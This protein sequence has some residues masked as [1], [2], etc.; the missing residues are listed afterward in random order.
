M[1]ILHTS[2][3]HLG[4][5]LAGASRE[6]DHE[7]FLAWLLRAV[8]ELGVDALVVA[9]DVF[10]QA[11]PT[12]DAQRAY[13]GFLAG[14]RGTGVRSVVIVGGNHDS[15]SR[16]DA[17]RELLRAFDV[18]VVGGM[19]IDEDARER[20]VVP[21]ARDGRIEAVVAA[22]P[23]VH[24][25]RLGV[26]TA[27]ADE[28]TIR[29]S[30]HE[31]FQS[32]YHGLAD[33]CE[34]AGSGAPIL[35]TGH[36]ACAGWEKGDS[37]TEI[38]MVG[39]LG[40]LPADVFDPRFAYVALGHVHRMMPVAGSSAWY[41]GSPVP[42]CLKESATARRLL[43]VD[44][45][46]T[47]RPVVTPIEVPVARHVVEI[48]GPVADVADRLRTLSWDTPLPPLVMAVIE[49]ESYRT[50]VEMDLQRAIEARGDAGPKLVLATQE[51]IG[52]DA[53]ATGD[54]DMAAGPPLRD[55]G[56]EDVFRRLCLARGETLDDRLLARF[57]SLVTGAAGGDAP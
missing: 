18:H 22:V 54:G 27:M 41:C 17:P 44:V 49:V 39:S 10:D 35:A 1:R 13:Y 9:G 57:R 4:S 50:G 16:L 55:L 53:G 46:G 23:Y 31:R 56:P 36:M 12:A 34:A 37:P 48:K 2:D 6:E 52:A 26:R 40:G 32:L 11:Q 19:P 51:R 21:L 25:F 38:H 5:S 24:E 30:F 45:T 42:L 8:D 7:R 33:R 29:K 28:A 3:W 43:L 15:P 14:L 20:C 47:D